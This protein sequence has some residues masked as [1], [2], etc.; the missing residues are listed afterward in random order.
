MPAAVRKSNSQKIASGIALLVPLGPRDNL[1]RS[2]S[3]FEGT[4]KSST[5]TTLHRVLSPAVFRSPYFSEQF[6]LSEPVSSPASIPR[7]V[8]DK[9]VWRSPPD[10]LALRNMVGRARRGRFGQQGTVNMACLAWER[11]SL[12]EEW[13][14]K[15]GEKRKDYMNDEKDARH[16][17]Q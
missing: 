15:G 16:F 8:R 7:K 6:S 2:T 4:G 17:A 1:D 14:R 12:C 13:Q 3:A 10:F 9:S 11:G 5:R